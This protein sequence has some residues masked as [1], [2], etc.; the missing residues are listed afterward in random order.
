VRKCGRNFVSGLEVCLAG[1]S[2]TPPAVL[3]A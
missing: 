2:Q 1:T 3:V